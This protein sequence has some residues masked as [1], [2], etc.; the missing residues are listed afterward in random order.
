MV[1][2]VIANAHVVHVVREAG[3]EFMAGGPGRNFDQWQPVA[4]NQFA[5]QC[6]VPLQG[7]HGGVCFRL[8]GGQQM[9]DLGKQ[10]IAHP[11]EWPSVHPA[12]LKYDLRRV[13][14]HQVAQISRDVPA[15][16]PEC[17]RDLC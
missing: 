10:I 1:E 5:E 2:F 13:F 12:P 16:M 6:D 17:A 15:L 14:F 8:S 11:H 7:G 9:T 4:Q 3:N